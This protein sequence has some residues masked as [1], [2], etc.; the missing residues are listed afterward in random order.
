MKKRAGLGVHGGIARDADKRAQLLDL[1][2]D[3]EGATECREQLPRDPLGTG[4]VRIWK[5]HREHVGGEACEAVLLA[6]L[7]L[8]AGRRI[9]QKGVARRVPEA[10]VDATQVFDADEEERDGRSEHPCTLLGLGDAVLQQAAVRKI[11]DRVIEGASFQHV[12]GQPT[13]GHVRQARDD[14]SH[15]AVVAQ[16]RHRVD[17]Q[18]ADGAVRRD[19][20]HHDISDGFV[21]ALRDHARE[22]VVGHRRSIFAKAR[23]LRQD[24]VSEEPRGGSGKDPPRSGVRKHDRASCVVHHDGGGDRVVDR[25]KV[26]PLSHILPSLRSYSTAVTLRQDLP[27]I[28]A[29]R[30]GL[31]ALR[32][33]GRDRLRDHRPRDVVPLRGVAAQPE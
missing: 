7:R 20:A 23:S 12:L 14:L 13:L 25:G 30:A 4:L 2:G 11:R 3:L 28:A 6:E 15:A 29:C 22:F 5:Q 1:A 32:E 27:L 16:D 21:E 24:A 31:V 8:H 9:H 26:A 17:E 18:P 19:G 10:F 33:P